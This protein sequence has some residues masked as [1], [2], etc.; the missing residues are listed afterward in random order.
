MARLIILSLL[1]FL[2]RSWAQEPLL[3]FGLVT[4]CQYAERENTGVRHFELSP[5]K[6]DQALSV[7]NQNKVNFT[8]SLG[9]LIDHNFD[10]YQVILP[11]LEKADSTVFLVL[12]NHEYYIKGSEFDQSMELLKIPKP[13]YQSISRDG[14]R[15][16]LLNSNEKLPTQGKTGIGS[17]QMDWLENEI[18]AARTANQKVIVMSHHPL[19]FPIPG[20]TMYNNSEVAEILEKNSD[21]VKAHFSG[22]QHLGGYGQQNGVHYMI[23]KGMVETLENRFSIVEIYQDRIVID[24]FGDEEDKVLKL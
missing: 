7:F 16:I 17:Q 20:I 24:G 8:V 12:G 14:F 1:L 15:L 23:F 3:R 22:H 19:Y 4:D 13:Y 21:L 11:I 9:D 6:L 5:Q 18:T 10:S 2:G